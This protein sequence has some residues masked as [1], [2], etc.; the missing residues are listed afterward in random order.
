MFKIN[1]KGYMLVEIILASVIAF[2]V[3]YFIINLTIKLKNKND[4][5][6]VETQ[7][8]TDQTIITNRLMEFIKEEREEFDCDELLVDVD[9]NKVLYRDSIID[10][11]NDYA[12]ID[13]S[14]NYCTKTDN[15]IN[16]RIPISVKQME[17]KDF[18]VNLDYNYYNIPAGLIRQ[19]IYTCKKKKDKVQCS[20]TAS[21]GGEYSTSSACNAACGNSCYSE[22]AGSGPMK[23]YCSLFCPAG[24][25]SGGYCILS[26]VVECPS[27]WHEDK[28]TSYKYEFDSSI[29]EVESCS[30]E[31][32][33]T[34]NSSTVDQSYVGS[35]SS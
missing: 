24:N 31:T 20:T 10:I 25:L 22:V 18:D 5:L 11:V 16:I 19:T 7:S 12:V 4:D 29:E 30:V 23:Y 32:S 34:C 15:S 21:G 17:D 2:G 28:T 3:A 9:N 26:N 1:N 27:G 14:D 33:F 35:C 13:D 6:F 8:V